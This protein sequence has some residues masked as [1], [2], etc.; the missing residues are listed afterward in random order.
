[1]E[2][3][4]MIREIMVNSKEMSLEDKKHLMSL[5]MSAYGDLSILV[6]FEEENTAHMYEEIKQYDT[7]KL[8][9]PSMVSKDNYMK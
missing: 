8:L 1:M 2:Y 6:A 9:K 5:L 7:K 4:K 3:E